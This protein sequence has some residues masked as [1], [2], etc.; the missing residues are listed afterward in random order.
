MH[1]PEYFLKKKEKANSLLS[2]S[3]SRV[4]LGLAYRKGWLECQ[5][6]LT[7]IDCWGGGGKLA[8]KYHRN[9]TANYTPPTNNLMQN[10]PDGITASQNQGNHK[11]ARVELAGKEGERGGGG[12][13]G[14]SG[15]MGNIQTRYLLLHGPLVS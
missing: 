1:S 4:R 8:M 3:V 10:Q 14:E 15:E 7:E 13:E 12:G 11:L 9:V 6:R 5:Q 2:W